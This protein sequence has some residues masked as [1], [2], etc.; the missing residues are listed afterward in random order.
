MHRRWGW[1]GFAL[2]S[3]RFITSFGGVHRRPR[4]GSDRQRAATGWRHTSIAVLPDWSPRSGGTGSAAKRLRGMAGWWAGSDIGGGNLATSPAFRQNQ[5]SSWRISAWFHPSISQWQQPRPSRAGLPKAGQ[6]CGATSADRGGL[7]L[8]VFPGPDQPRATL[9]QESLA[10]PIPRHTAWKRPQEERLWPTNLS[11]SLSGPEKLADGGNPPRSHAETGRF[12]S[13]P[14]AQQAHIRQQLMRLRV[15]V[16]PKPKEGHIRKDASKAG[17][18]GGTDHGLEETLVSHYQPE[19][20]RRWSLDRGSSATHS[21][22]RRKPT[23]A[24]R[25]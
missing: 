21:P 25:A 22:V 23:R 14:I 17:K 2:R 1:L 15:A 19:L 7:E 11:A 9:R 3:A 12:R 5:A 6:R 10:K 18:A 24:I 8:S 13:G 16:P 4:R 20:I